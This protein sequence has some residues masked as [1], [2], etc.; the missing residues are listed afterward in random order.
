MVE[1]SAG[2]LRVEGESPREDRLGWRPL[3]KAGG[4]PR[5]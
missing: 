5:L 4:P 3:S 1:S 2:Y